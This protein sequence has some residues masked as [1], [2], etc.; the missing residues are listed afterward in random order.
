M[1]RAIIRQAMILSIVVAVAAVMGAPITAHAQV[2]CTTGIG[3]VY[4]AVGS[5]NAPMLVPA[6]VPLTTCSDRGRVVGVIPAFQTVGGSSVPLIVPASL[7]VK[8][9]APTVVVTS[10]P[11]TGFTTPAVINTGLTPATGFSPALQ[12]VQVSSGVFVLGSDSTVT[13]TTPTVVN[14]T[15]S[16]AFTCF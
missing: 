16:R 11:G 3:T 14:V 6:S 12:F 7:P 10:T 13:S 1:G 15:L 4:R 9:C 8:T 2:T 5:P